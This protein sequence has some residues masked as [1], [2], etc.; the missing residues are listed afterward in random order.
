MSKYTDGTR[1]RCTADHKTPLRKTGQNVDM[2]LFLPVGVSDTKLP[3]RNL[4]KT[5]R[6]EG[7]Q[8]PQ[9]R[10]NVSSIGSVPDRCKRGA[11][12]GRKK[13]RHYSTPSKL[14]KKN[15]NLK[16]M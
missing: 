13:G 7:S 12:A 14:K 10:V 11:L 1:L 8:S 3:S 4:Y 9:F 5:F 15:Q 16:I 6:M 2:R